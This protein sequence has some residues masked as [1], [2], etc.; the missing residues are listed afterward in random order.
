MRRLVTLSLSFFV[1]L[2]LLAGCG[3]TKQATTSTSPKTDSSGTTSSTGPGTYTASFGDVQITLTLPTTED[4]TVQAIK[5]FSSKVEALKPSNQTPITFASFTVKN[6]SSSPTL[7]KNYTFS[8]TFNAGNQVDGKQASEYVGNIQN[9][10]PSSDESG[11]YNEGVDL[12]NKLIEPTDI[13]PGASRTSYCVFQVGNLAGLKK[14]FASYYSGGTK[15][16]KK[17]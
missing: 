6:G 9:A 4:A 14:V 8:L 13:M 17:Q 16:M 10:I 7:C 2:L 1:I 11:L 3:S 5:A 12:Y 15:E